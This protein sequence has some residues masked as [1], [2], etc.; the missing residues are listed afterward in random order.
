MDVLMMSWIMIEEESH[1]EFV[2]NMFHSLFIKIIIYTWNVFNFPWKAIIKPF[3]Y[4]YA[5]IYIY[6]YL[7]LYRELWS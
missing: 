3:M 1:V 4:R 2:S 5:S 6:I 7:Q